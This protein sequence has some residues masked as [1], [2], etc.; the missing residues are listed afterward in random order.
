MACA[1]NPT[2]CS[3]FSDRSHID[4]SREDSGI[5]RITRSARLDSANV[6]ATGPKANLPYARRLVDAV[7]TVARVVPQIGALGN[8]HKACGAKSPALAKLGNG[9]DFRVQV[10]RQRVSFPQRTANVIPC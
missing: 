6:V 3:E 1:Y 10:A 2:S 8:R 5:P 4:F 9:H 7:A